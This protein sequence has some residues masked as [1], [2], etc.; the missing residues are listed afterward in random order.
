MRLISFRSTRVI[1]NLYRSPSAVQR[2]HE[3]YE[4]LMARQ[5][6]AWSYSPPNRNPNVDSPERRRQARGRHNAIRGPHFLGRPTSVGSARASNPSFTH[7]PPRNFADLY[8]P[9][10]NAASEA[11]AREARE[12]RERESRASILASAVSPFRASWDQLTSDPS[13]GPSPA[14][15]TPPSLPAGSSVPREEASPPVAVG[16]GV[17]ARRLV[18]QRNSA[19]SRRSVDS[20]NSDFMFDSPNDPRSRQSPEEPSIE[21]RHPHQIEPSTGVPSFGAL[22]EVSNNTARFGSDSSSD[23]DDLARISRMDAGIP[24]GWG[25]IN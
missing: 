17:S 11:A 1:V 25:S 2:A 24:P 12:A 16:S 5:A 21:A 22:L 23:I 18:D 10:R 14:G 15:R 6:D 4:F 13:S 7:P 8:S 3:E 9:R 20:D 19:A